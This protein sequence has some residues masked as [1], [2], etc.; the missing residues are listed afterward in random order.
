MLSTSIKAVEQI[1]RGNNSAG[2]LSDVMEEDGWKVLLFF[3][4]I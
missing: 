3:E 1:F 2:K 4:V